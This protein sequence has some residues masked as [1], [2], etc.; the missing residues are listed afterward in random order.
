[1][2]VFWAAAS[3]RSVPVAGVYGQAAGVVN[4]VCGK[5]WVNGSLPSPATGGAPGG[6]GFGVAGLVVAVVVAAVL[7]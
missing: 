2:G 5:G 4:G 3:N 1:M 7:V 6:G